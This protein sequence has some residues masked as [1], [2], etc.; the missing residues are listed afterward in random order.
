MGEPKA[1]EGKVKLTESGASALRAWTQR[2]GAGLADLAEAMGT[3]QMAPS[4]AMKRQGWLTLEQ[5]GRLVAFAGGELT[6][7]MLVGMERAGAVPVYPPRARRAAPLP[8]QAAAA[9]SPS[10]TPPV[11]SD[12]DEDGPP[13]IEELRRLGRKGL[14]RLEALV[15]ANDTAATASA[16]SAHRLVK[17]WIAA[18]EL[19][20]AKEKEG[21]VKEVDLIQ[22]FET[23]LYH[24]R[25]AAAEAET[26]PA[27]PAKEP[28]P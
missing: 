16:E 22:K 23:L 20:R 4:R 18:E 1:I 14:K 7:E 26:A 9:P 3:N 21:A 27:A 5:T 25:R 28:S 24:A 15:D 6:A 19:E 11:D 17:G 8:V 2:T 13:S 10:S 12:A